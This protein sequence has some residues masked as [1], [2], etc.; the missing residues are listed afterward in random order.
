MCSDQSDVWSLNQKITLKPKIYFPSI[1]VNEPVK[2]QT[3]PTGTKTVT[4]VISPLIPKKPPAEGIELEA[5]RECRRAVD[6]DSP[7]HFRFWLE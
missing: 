6:L 5:Q 3:Y 1:L 4:I 2:D 7:W